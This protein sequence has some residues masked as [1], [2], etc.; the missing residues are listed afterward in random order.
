MENLGV[1]SRVEEPTPWCAGIV[2]VPKSRGDVRICVDLRHL[3]QSVMHEVHPLPKVEETLA[4]LTGAKLF[5]KLDA[6]SGFWQIRLAEE[7][8]L[9]TTFI[10][11]FG[12][13]CFKTNYPSGLRAPL[14]IFKRGCHEF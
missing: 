4:Q 3:N 10:T 8:R 5:S 11:P 7:S 1:I 12:R 13:Y 14:S 6:N 2:A 9:L